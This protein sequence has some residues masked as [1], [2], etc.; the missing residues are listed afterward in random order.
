MAGDQ[1]AANPETKGKGLRV[2][3]NKFIFLKL[4]FKN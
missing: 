3:K 2:L 1:S 4:D